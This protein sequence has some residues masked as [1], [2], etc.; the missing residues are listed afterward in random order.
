[1]RPNDNVSYLNIALKL[2]LERL[3]IYI[4][5]FLVISILETS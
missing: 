3:L 5:F 2:I 1:M 4:I